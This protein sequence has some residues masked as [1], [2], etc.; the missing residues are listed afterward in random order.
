MKNPLKS[1]KFQRFKKSKKT[2][3]SDETQQ[4]RK[5]KKTKPQKTKKKFLARLDSIQ[6]GK[7][8]SLLVFETTGFTLYG[9]LFRSG[10]SAS[11]TPEAVASSR[12]IDFATAVAEIL[13]QLGEQSKKKL[14]KTAVLITPSAASGLIFLPVNPEEPQPRAQ[15]NELVRW[16]I[17]PM[18]ARQNGIW[19]IGAL[20]MGREY[21]TADERKEIAAGAGP[22]IRFGNEACDLG[23]ATREQVDECLKL[24]ESLALFD[25]DVASDWVPQSGAGEQGDDDGMFTWYGIGLGESMRKQWVKAF[26]RQ[27]ISLDWVY[28]QFGLVANTIPDSEREWMLVDIRQEQFAV[29]RGQAGKLSSMRV[30]SWQDGQVSGESIAELCRE[31]IRSDIQEIY[32]LSDD[33]VYEDISAMLGKVLRRDISRISLPEMVVKTESIPG[34]VLLSVMGAASH[35]LGHS[36][37][38]SIPRVG[39]KPPPPPLWKRKDLYAPVAMALLVMVIICFDLSLRYRTSQNELALEQLDEEYGQKLILKKQTESTASEVRGLQERL[40]EKHAAIEELEHKKHIMKDVILHRV[41]LVPALL[42]AISSAMGNEVLIDSI[43]ED[44]GRRA[45]LLTGL[46]LTDSDG[47]AFA[48]RLNNNLQAL[49]Y[50][51]EDVKL[52]RGLGRLDITGYTLEI[53]VTPVTN[54]QESAL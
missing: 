41:L 15:M 17:E 20:L 7:P 11:T 24:Q 6:L 22:D 1:I 40:A 42:R 25:D 38:N 34:Q 5:I 26:D 54:L 35:A 16:E 52:Y 30:E 3:E 45:I 14:P 23:Y 49:N 18:F 27:K 46:A 8:Q 51:V 31:E 21:I 4:N 9:A 32:L 39:A 43:E 44:K 10:F 47:Q 19:F 50:K 48:N 28:P 37:L 36:S 2:E 53:I 13:E 33:R 29:L 12:A